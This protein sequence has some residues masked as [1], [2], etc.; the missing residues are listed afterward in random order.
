M[1]QLENYHL[2]FAFQILFCLADHEGNKLHDGRITAVL[3]KAHIASVRTMPGIKEIF[4]FVKF[5]NIKHP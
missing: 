5:M 1:L 4:I 2:L 3:S